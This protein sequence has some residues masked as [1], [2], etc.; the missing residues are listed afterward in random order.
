MHCNTPNNFLFEIFY[1]VFGLIVEVS[2]LGAA[3]L[4]TLDLSLAFVLRLLFRLVR[5]GLKKVGL[6]RK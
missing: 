2:A 5:T 3:F 1:F 4:L 6:L